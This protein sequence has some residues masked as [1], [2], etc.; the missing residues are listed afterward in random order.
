MAHRSGFVITVTSRPR[1]PRNKPG[2]QAS[3]ASEIELRD[4][5]GAAA[6][7]FP[8]QIKRLNQLVTDRLTDRA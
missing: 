6:S 5:A 1:D 2:E 7:P 4:L 3:A 8:D